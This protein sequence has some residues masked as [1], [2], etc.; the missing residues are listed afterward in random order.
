MAYWKL[1]VSWCVSARASG[2]LHPANKPPALP[3]P[4][5]WRC[6]SPVFR[7][8]RVAGAVSPSLSGMARA[9]PSRSIGPCLGAAS[10][11]QQVLQGDYWGSNSLAPW[12]RQ[13]SIQIRYRS[14]FAV[15]GVADVQCHAAR[16]PRWRHDDSG[17][18]PEALVIQPPL[19]THPALGRRLDQGMTRFPRLFAA[20][21]S[22]SSQ[23]PRLSRIHV[24]SR[25]NSAFTPFQK[26][27]RCTATGMTLA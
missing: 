8:R 22:R 19:H 2:I 24:P 27:H 6:C 11:S 13:T 18:K 5:D 7:Q 4:W 26:W 1:L 14:N 10:S 17:V 21:S 15:P 16:E 23:L 9:G 12:H 25:S 3:T 20:V